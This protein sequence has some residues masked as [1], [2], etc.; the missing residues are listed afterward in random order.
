MNWAPTIQSVFN[1]YLIPLFE[2]EKKNKKE[3]LPFIWL[4]KSFT[5]D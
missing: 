3:K 4:T 1:F 5:A 2:A